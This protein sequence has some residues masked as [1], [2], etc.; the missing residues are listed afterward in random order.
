MAKGPPGSGRFAATTDAAE[1]AD[2][3]SKK[4]AAAFLLN[5]TISVRLPLFAKGQFDPLLYGQSLFYNRMAKEL[6]QIVRSEV[7]MLSAAPIIAARLLL[8]FT[9]HTARLLQGSQAISIFRRLP[10]E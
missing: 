2:L 7:G 1:T 8:V 10:D 6:G 5:G 9:G 3:P 4:A